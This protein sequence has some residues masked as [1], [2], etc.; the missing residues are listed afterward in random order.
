[1][2]VT[3]QVPAPTPVTVVPETLQTVEGVTVKVMGVRVAVAA[4]VPELVPI[5]E[6]GVGLTK[7]IV[8]AT[9]EFTMLIVLVTSAAVYLMLSPD[10]LAAMIQVPTEMAVTIAPETVQVEDCELKV[11]ASPEE[12]IAVKVLDAP[13]IKEE[14]VLKVMVCGAIPKLADIVAAGSRIELSATPVKV[15]SN[16]L[17]FGVLRSSNIVLLPK[18]YRSLN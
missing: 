18:K 14:G 7:V 17:L 15:P 4:N 12:A 1:M 3:V 13:T 6:V 2:A 5:K 10:W 8:C 11:T 9:L 16:S